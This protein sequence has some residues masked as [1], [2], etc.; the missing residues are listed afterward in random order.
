[1]DLS[2]V[3]GVGLSGVFAVTVIYYFFTEWNAE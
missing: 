3:L 1:M 2:C